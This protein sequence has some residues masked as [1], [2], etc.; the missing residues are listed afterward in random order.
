MQSKNII[1]RILLSS[2]L[3]IVFS[4]STFAEDWNVPADKKAKNSFIKFD[5]STVKNGQANYQKNC[6]SCHGDI[7]KNNSLKSLNPIPPDLST[8]NAQNLTDGELFYILNTGRGLMPSFK[9]ILSEKER[10]EVISYIR[11]FNSSYVQVLSKTDPS[12]SELVKINVQF[13]E[14]RQQIRVRVT[15][16]EKVGIIPL[17]DAEVSLFAKRYFGKLQIDNTLRTD[18]DGYANFK[19]IKDLPG[20]KTG[21]IDFIVNV[22]DEVYGEIVSESIIKVG[23]PTDKPALNEQRAIWNVLTKA[24]IWIIILYVAGIST[25]AVF[26]LFLLSNLMKIYKTGKNK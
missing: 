7:G 17:K 1:T 21:N 5:N 9:N 3:T 20:D 13:D 19:F 26:L 15:L 14:A 25:F 2:L 22:N 16:A 23:I 8:K 18:V 4:I 6:A 24:P 10:W 11:S 12:K